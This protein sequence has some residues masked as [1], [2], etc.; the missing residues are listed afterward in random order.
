MAEKTNAPE[1]IYALPESLRA[2][3]LNYLSARPYAEVA[4]GVQSLLTLQPVVPADA[5]PVVERE[6]KLEA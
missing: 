1:A 4:G 6:L 2:A 5:A 3:L